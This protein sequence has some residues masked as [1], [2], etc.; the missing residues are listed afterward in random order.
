[1][2]S[3]T[4]DKIIAKLKTLGVK[5]GSGLMVHSSLKSFGKVDG[6]PRTVV[7]ALMELVTADGLLLMPSF[8]HGEPFKKEAAYYEP[9]ST[10]TTNGAIPD[11]F[12]RLP[13]VRRSLNPTHPYAAWG[14][15][16]DEYVKDHHKTLTMGLDSPLG[17]LM[18]DDG[19]CLL[20]GIGYKAATIKHL[21]ETAMN[22]PCL[23]KRT[24]AYPVKLASGELV[25][26]R[27]WG[28][29]EA[30]CP[31]LDPPSPYL[32]QEMR[33]QGLEKTIVIGEC[34]VIMFRLKDCFDL[35]TEILRNGREDH[36]PCEKCKIR[37]RKVKYT[38]PS[39]L[40]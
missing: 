38:V 33:H 3:L 4:K 36:P 2:T 40:N 1:V 29:R 8:N 20:M 28:W 25:Q 24:E 6:G 7:D 26:G 16:A 13:G 31:L 27:T 10:P 17:L 5:P 14:A 19:Y 39:D 30:P 22:A 32:E 34:H 11:C 12:W 23:G 35:A 37:P 21:A 15:K 9:S 18:A